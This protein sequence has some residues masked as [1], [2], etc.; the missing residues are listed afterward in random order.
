MK[1]ENVTME[2]PY[3]DFV[4]KNL[5]ILQENDRKALEKLVSILEEHEDI[6]DVYTSTEN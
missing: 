5:V 4:P 2:E 6:Q 1:K 3:M